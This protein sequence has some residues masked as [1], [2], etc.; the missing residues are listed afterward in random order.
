MNVRVRAHL[1]VVNICMRFGCCVII[2]LTI[3][4]HASFLFTTS[5]YPWVKLRPYRAKLNTVHLNIKLSGNA[6]N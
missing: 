5:R 6:L 1:F 4:G 2:I 3:K